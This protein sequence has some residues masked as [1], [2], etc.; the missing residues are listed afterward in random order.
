YLLAPNA[1]YPS[2][3]ASLGDDFILVVRR[4]SR[5]SIGRAHSAFEAV[6]FDANTD[7]ASI[8]VQPRTLLASPEEGWQWKVLVAGRGHTL[9]VVY[10]RIDPEA[11]NVP[12][13]F[14]RLY[15]AASPRR[16]ATR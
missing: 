8:P 1:A 4:L 15:S 16:R 2:V 12:R 9:G 3:A 6:M 5:D 10:A 14:L 13:T 11:G 7:L